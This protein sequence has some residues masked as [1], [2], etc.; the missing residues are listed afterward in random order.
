MIFFEP[1]I[2]FFMINQ[3]PTPTHNAVTTTKQ[4]C[5]SN[6]IHQI[7]VP[8]T[9][10]AYLAVY[11]GTFYTQAI[12]FDKN[13]GKDPFVLVTNINVCMQKMKARN[14]KVVFSKKITDETL[15]RFE[16]KIRAMLEKNM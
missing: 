3:N 7:Y 1:L 5:C 2:L 9:E 6:E 16:G 12:F 13:R 11:N 15:K 10:R 8:A 4:P 14:W